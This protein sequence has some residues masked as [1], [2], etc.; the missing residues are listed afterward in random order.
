MAQLPDHE[1][2]SLLTERLGL[3]AGSLRP[4]LALEALRSSSYVNERALAPGRESLRSNERLEFL[5]DAALGMVIAQRCYD[6]FPDAPEGDLTRLRASLVR[7]ESLAIVARGLGLGDLLLVG[8]GDGVR[9]NPSRLADALEAVLA[10]VFLSCG[11][12]VLQELL[13]RLL[14]P[15]FEQML[16]LGRDP[17]TELQ[18]YFQARRRAP[19]YCVIAA[20]GPPHE[21]EYEIEARLD[22][23]PLARGVGR[24]KKEAEQA[25]ART[26]LE[27][28]EVLERALLDEPVTVE[29]FDPRWTALAAAETARLRT[30]LGEVEVHHIGSTAVPGLP[31]RAIIDLA[32]SPQVPVPK[33]P[34]YEPAGPRSFRKRGSRGAFNLRLVQADALADD[35]LLRD[36]LR[37]HPD[38]AAQ[39]AAD[40]RSLVAAGATGSLRYE[41]EKV[42][43]LQA[44]LARAKS[45]DTIRISPPPGTAPDERGGE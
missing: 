15:L 4:E 5:G 37:A 41:D 8:R 23:V 22:S 9:D 35:L 25:A 28:P 32:V 14:A 3:P 39:Y 36:F 43:L 27:Q 26:A 29:E 19:Q 12:A 18:H 20:V 30:A 13:E 2:I 34:E 40:K 38:A 17:K 33:L 16:A 7:E 11:M 21:R 42:P 31:A 1:R 6:R 44:L 10:A 24:S 45:G